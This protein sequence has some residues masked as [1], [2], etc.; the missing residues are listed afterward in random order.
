METDDGLRRKVLAVRER[1]Y[2]GVPAT[3]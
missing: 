3:L 2:D 1:L